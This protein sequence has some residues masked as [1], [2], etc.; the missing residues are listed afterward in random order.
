MWCPMQCISL[1]FFLF[2]ALMRC[3]AWSIKSIKTSPIL[4]LDVMVQIQF[5]HK[6][7]VE[8][9]TIKHLICTMSHLHN[10]TATFLLSHNADWMKPSASQII[11][12]VLMIHRNVIKLVWFIVSWIHVEILLL[13]LENWNKLETTCKESHVWGYED[14]TSFFSNLG[15]YSTLLIQVCDFCAS[16]STKQK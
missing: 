6:S 15:Q 12:R 7:A 13:P 8:V 4:H 11:I 5:C 2:C 9:K 16:R 10:C 3:S 14:E 1:F